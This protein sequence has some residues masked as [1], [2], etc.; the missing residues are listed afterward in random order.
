MTLKRSESAL[1]WGCHITRVTT[2]PCTRTMAGAVGAPGDI[3]PAYQ[4]QATFTEGKR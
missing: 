4:P 1:N 2:E 3:D